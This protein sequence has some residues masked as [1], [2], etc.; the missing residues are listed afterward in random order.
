VG[1]SQGGC[2][3]L[4]LDHHWWEPMG[5]VAYNPTPG[6]DAAIELAE[7]RRHFFV[8]CRFTDPFGNHTLVKYDIHDLFL[9]RRE[10][11]V[12]NVASIDL[13]YRVLAP[14]QLVN[15]NG[16]I[17]QVA[18]NTLGIVLVLRSYKE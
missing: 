12:Y 4:D 15:I 11:A 1:E 6:V 16:N 2:V 13:E 18:F 14:K 10:N 9:V 5:T 7:A 17:S 3:D 8:P